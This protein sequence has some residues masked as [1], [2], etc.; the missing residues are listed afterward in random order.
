MVFLRLDDLTVDVSRI[1]TME[2]VGKTIVIRMDSGNV[3]NCHYPNLEVA[4]NAYDKATDLIIG[5][6]EK[7]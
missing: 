6:K 7:E 4:K 2:L 5:L 1:E 3:Y